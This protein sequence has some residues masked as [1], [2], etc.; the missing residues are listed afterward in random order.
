VAA[1]GHAEGG[2]VRDVLS[3][4]RSAGVSSHD[5]S[6]VLVIALMM[7]LVFAPDIEDDGPMPP[8]S[9]ADIDD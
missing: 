4:R 6:V 8:G 9:P 3:R 5:N 1:V 2:G 7:T